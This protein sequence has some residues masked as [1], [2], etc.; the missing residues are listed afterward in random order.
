MASKAKSLRVGRDREQ[1]VNEFDKQRPL[2]KLARS[3][4]AS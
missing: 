3:I 2:F 4:Q 1:R